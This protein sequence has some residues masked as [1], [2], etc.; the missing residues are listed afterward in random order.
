VRSTR[1][2]LMASALILSTVPACASAALPLSVGGGPLLGGYLGD[3]RDDWR[4]GIGASAFV[5][6]EIVSD[7]DA[8]LIG[9]IQWNDGSLRPRD[10]DGG[11]A[12]LGGKPGESPRSCRRSSIAACAVYRLESRAYRDF[13]VPYAGMGVECVEREVVFDAPD[14]A[15]EREVT[16]R[17]GGL[18]AIAGLRF[19]RTSGLFISLEAKLHC[20]D[21]PQQWTTAYD[22]S[23]LVGAQLGL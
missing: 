13:L 7:L 12:A 5:E 22:A 21:T 16:G 6:T 18:L 23:L 20:L 4:I 14:L 1:F 15:H 17:D 3:V 2:V 10:A 8:R 9:S 19:Y 11:M